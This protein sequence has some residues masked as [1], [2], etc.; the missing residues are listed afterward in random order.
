MNSGMTQ[1]VFEE[2]LH[3]RYK[4]EEKWGEQD[5]PSVDPVLTGRNCGASPERLCEEYEIPTEDRAKFLCNNAAGK[6]VITW[7]HIA[8]EEL[9]E[10]I[11][12]Y[13]DK[14]RREELIQLAAVVVEWISCIDRKNIANGSK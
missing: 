7:A 11:S 14:T 4:Q 12:A 3:E 5:H 6:N 2:I 9:S 1:R 10:A 13:D 8:V